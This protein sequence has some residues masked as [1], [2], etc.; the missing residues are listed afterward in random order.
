M[1]EPRILLLDG[2]MGTTLEAMGHD[3]STA[4][5]GSDLLC[6]NPQAIQEVHEGY[7]KAG[8]DLVETATYQLTADNVAK[9]MAGDTDECH[10]GRAWNALKRS[11][12]LVSDSVFP[13]SDP[14]RGGAESSVARGGKGVVLSFGPYGSTL[15]PGQEYG[16]LYPPPFG[17]STSS[18]GFP[19]GEAYAVAE[20]GVIEALAKFHTEKLHIFAMDEPTWRRVDWIA[21][22]TIPVIH[23]IRAIRRAMSRL[24]DVLARRHPEPEG[25]GRQWWDKRFWITSPFPNGQHPQVLSGSS[26]SGHEHATVNQVVRAMLEGDDT[27]PDGM[28]INCTH[29][30]YLSDLCG[31][32]SKAYVRAQTPA[33][34]SNM[35]FVLYPDGGQVYDTKTRTWSPSTMA[36]GPDDWASQI[37]AIA[38]E[39]EQAKDTEGQRIWGG[40]VLGGC[41]KTSFAE[42]AALRRLLDEA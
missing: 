7:V 40:V 41:C 24:N 4:L 33:N 15:S 10:L 8:A 3:V 39:V 2:G 13:E 1:E 32:F 17:P 18:N 35:R 22:E 30:K 31:Q 25:E 36:N 21:F 16:G 34:G 14:S 12:K 28:G 11:V 37:L 5:W 23:E 27:R 9:F 26:G 38:R 20:E 29:P 19:T 42:I 6:T